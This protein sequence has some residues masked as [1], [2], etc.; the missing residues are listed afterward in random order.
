MLHLNEKVE[1]GMTR[2]PLAGHMSADTCRESRGTFA[3]WMRAHFEREGR[4]E[5]LRAEHGGS[6]AET[7]AVLVVGLGRMAALQHR[8]STP[9]QIR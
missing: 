7:A 2:C 9:H 6:A 1:C 4:M 5:G 3:A 8:A